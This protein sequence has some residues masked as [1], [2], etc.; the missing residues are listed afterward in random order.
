MIQ[1]G[2][3]AVSV[4]ISPRYFFLLFVLHSFPCCFTLS[5]L[6]DT[7]IFKWIITNYPIPF[8]SLCIRYNNFLFDIFVHVHPWV[9]FL[10]FG[11]F[12]KVNYSTI[13]IIII[14]A[15]RQSFV[16]ELRANKRNKYVPKA[17]SIRFE[18]TI[19]K[20]INSNKLSRLYMCTS[21][22]VSF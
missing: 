8:I 7:S 21:A 2:P 19:T 10:L 18:R 5:S 9:L 15:A 4:T 13:N 11:N 1:S 12:F 17:I 3:W 22:R 20:L 16:I 6:I 14:T